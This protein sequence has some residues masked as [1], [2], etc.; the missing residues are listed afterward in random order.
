MSFQ[1][2]QWLFPIAVTLHNGEEALWFPDWSRKAARWPAPVELG[3]FGFAVAVFTLL[4]FVVTWLSVRS[5]K[6]TLWTYLFFGYMAAVLANAFIP[7]IAVSA[8]TRS[9]MPGVATATLVNFPVL[10]LMIWLA[11]K[12][13]FVS[14]WKAAGYS[15]C[16]ACILLVSIPLLFKLGRVLKLDGRRPGT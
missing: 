6:Q 3:V 1:S 9:Y 10:S 11:F 4:A 2:L 8:A 7:H 16:V 15:S 5:G 13:E 14:G 12:E